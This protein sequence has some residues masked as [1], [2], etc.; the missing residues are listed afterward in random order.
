V[1]PE[2]TLLDIEDKL[3]RAEVHIARLMLGDCGLRS[4]FIWRWR[5][6][7]RALE[8]CWRVW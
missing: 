7:Y 8:W 5:G 4:D 3:D 6:V 2:G 1:F